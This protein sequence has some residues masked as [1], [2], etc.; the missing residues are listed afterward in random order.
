MLTQWLRPQRDRGRGDAHPG[1]DRERP[2]GR[3]HRRALRL[4]RQLD[5]R[6]GGGRV[7][8]AGHVARREHGRR[9]VVRLRRH[10]GRERGP[11]VS[12]LTAPL[13]AAER[14]L[15]VESHDRA[16]RGSAATG[17]NN[18]RTPR[19]RRGAT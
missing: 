10:R 18:S 11:R 4:V 16:K 2:A 19:L 15:A 12:A 7:R 5:R 14:R 1:H 17:K 3:G 6:R 8:R 9:G 13:T